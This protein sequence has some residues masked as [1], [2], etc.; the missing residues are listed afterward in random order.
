[1]KTAHRPAL[2]VLEDFAGVWE[3]E[4]DILHA[5]GDTGHLSGRLDMRH[6][7]WGLLYNETGTLTMGSAA[8]VTATRHYR[9]HTGLEVHFED[10]RFFHT[11]PAGGGE[12]RHWCAPDDYRVHYDFSDWPVWRTHWQVSGPRKNY[13]MFTRY[14][15]PEAL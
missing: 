3:L 10:G 9:W 14:S 6:Q 11:V 8:P 5:S 13:Q 1:M 15:R 12:A 2:R 4:R 7:S